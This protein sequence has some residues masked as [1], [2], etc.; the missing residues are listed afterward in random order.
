M[1]DMGKGDHDNGE[2]YDPGKLAD[3]ERYVRAGFWDKIRSTASKI[4]FAEDAVAAYYCALDRSTPT[5]VKAMLLG[6]LAYF[7]MPTDVIPDFIAGL[8][9]TDD[10]SVLAATIAA[11]GRH[12]LPAHRD[13]ARDLLNKPGQLPPDDPPG[14][15]PAPA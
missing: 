2:K 14:P 5:Y 8:G 3:D 9:F 4:P 6:A 11:I 10:A 1:R 13:K 12:I 7:I 15:G